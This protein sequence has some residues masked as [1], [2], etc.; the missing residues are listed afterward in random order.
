MIDIDF[1]KKEMSYLKRHIS[2][3]NKKLP[4]TTAIFNLGSAKNCPSLKKGYCLI[5]AKRCYAMKAEKQYKAVR[6]YR[7]R[8]RKLFS[9]LSAE[10][11]AVMFLDIQSRKRKKFKV[12]RFNEAGDFK[13]QLDVQKVE[14]IAELLKPHKIN[15][16]AYTANKDL[17]FSICKTCTINASRPDINGHNRF[18]AVKVF[19]GKNL[20]C[21]G[22]CKSC[23]LCEIKLNKTIEVELH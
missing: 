19:S 9:S 13:T 22:S 2:C 11:F 5:G 12:L 21:P 8:Q 16:Y 20:T 3:G 4:S 14:R 23:S 7:E 6:P 18:K 1:T 15:V 17:D 10:Q